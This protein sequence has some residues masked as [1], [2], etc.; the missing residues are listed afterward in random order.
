MFTIEEYF[1][2]PWHEDTFEIE[3]Q[4]ERF[5]IR[6]LDGLDTL[7]LYELKELDERFIHILAICLLDGHTNQPVGRQYAE[8]FIR[9]HQQLA[10]D[11]TVKIINLSCDLSAEEERLIDNAKKN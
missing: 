3:V 11:L 10:I 4:Q 5:K 6:R 9:R 7:Q 1:Q 8:Q 2:S